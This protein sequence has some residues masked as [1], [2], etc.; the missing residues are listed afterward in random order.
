MD[1]AA[2]GDTVVLRCGTYH[3]WDIQYKPDTTL[4]SETGDPSCVTIDAGGKGRCLNIVTEIQ[5]EFIYAWITG[6]TFINGQASSGVLQVGGAVYCNDNGAY[7]FTECEFLN[8]HAIGGGAVG[9][10]WFAGCYFE[11]CTFKHN[12]SSG[13]GGAFWGGEGSGRFERCVFE[14]NQSGGA[15][16]AASTYT[17]YY[18]GGISA[19]DSEFRTNHASSAGGAISI[20]GFYS[21]TGYRVIQDSHREPSL[22]NCLFI[23]NTSSN[24]GAIYNFYGA[25][26]YRYCHFWGNSAEQGGVIFAEYWDVVPVSRG[27]L[28]DQCSFISNSAIS[29]GL[30][31]GQGYGSPSF[32]HCL[33][34]DNTGEIVNGYENW[35]EEFVPVFTCCDIWGNQTGDWTGLIADQLGENGNISLDPLLCPGYG[36]ESAYL[37]ADSPCAE[38]N[39][40]ECGQIG[41]WPVGCTAA[42]SMTWSEIKTLY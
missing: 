16:G 2:E 41:A 19:F 36:S 30:L 31:F 5:N 1:A 4:R 40:P 21:N 33:V 10:S 35:F 3:E 39:N 34:A 37:R 32:Q 24:G 22:E 17:G 7:T 23:D 38:G 15:G 29:G 25:R 11:D 8:N 13:S 26:H 12:S 27:A 18:G 20:D 14:S 28:F 42:R 6:I 9:V